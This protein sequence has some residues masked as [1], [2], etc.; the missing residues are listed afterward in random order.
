VSAAAFGTWVGASVHEVAQVVSAAAPAGP[1]AMKVAS[2]V[3][4]TRVLML[5][6]LVLAVGLLRRRAGRAEGRI[7]RAPVPLFIGG[8]LLCVGVASSRAVPAGLMTAANS[9]DIGLLT[10]SLAG[11][12]LGVDVRQI[13]RLGWRPMVLGFGSWA[14]AAVTAL[15]GAALMIR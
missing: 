13:A 12:G 4:L 6:P 10:A 7:V 9:I 11:L 15:T 5:A 14:I 8:F 3:K 1:S 2:V